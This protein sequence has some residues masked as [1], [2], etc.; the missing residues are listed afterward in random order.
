MKKIT[1]IVLIASILASC[2]STYQPL[3]AD[4]QS[5]QQQVAK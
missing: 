3:P 5:A 4:D 1:T 2:V